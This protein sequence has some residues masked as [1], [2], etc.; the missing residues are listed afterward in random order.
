MATTEEKILTENGVTK[1][2]TISNGTAATT[3]TDKSITNGLTA[4]GTSNI[5][6]GTGTS[7]SPDCTFKF[8]TGGSYLVNTEEEAIKYYDNWANTYDEWTQYCGYRGPEYL[9]DL[10]KQYCKPTDLFLIVG[11]GTG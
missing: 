4:N 2:S 10:V 9:A 8:T 7:S 3:A 6:Y 1:K 11:V 5:V